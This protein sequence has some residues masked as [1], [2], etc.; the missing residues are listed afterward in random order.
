MKAIKG[1]DRNLQCRG[2]QFEVGKTYTAT[3][4]IKACENGFHAIPEDVHPFYVWEFY[5]VTDSRFFAVEL[6]GKTDADGNK[7]AAEILTVGKEL[8]IAGLVAEAVAWVSARAT[9]GGSELSSGYGANIGS[10]GDGAKIGSSGYGA[11]IGSS[12][13]GANIGS[14]GDGAKIGSS[15]YGAKIGSSGDYAKIGSSGDYANIDC[16]GKGAV[17]ASAGR[18]TRFKGKAGAWFSLA[19]YDDGGKCN[20]FATG[21]VGQNG[22]KPDTWYRAEGGKLVE[23]K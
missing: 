14:S 7:V 1:F 3:G 6:A 4:K 18:D 19:S 8:G 16:D 17:A 2:F 21:C 23:E 11:N 22:I 12:G 10:S 15:G 5:P 20:G 13:Y 9:A